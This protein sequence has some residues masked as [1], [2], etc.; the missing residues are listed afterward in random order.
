MAS[1]P[2]DPVDT[3]AP[4]PKNRPRARK[5]TKIRTGAGTA[6]GGSVKTRG[7]HFIGRDF[8][9][10]VTNEVRQGENLDE[11]RSVIAHYL[12]ALSS[13][14]TGLKLGEID[15][16]AQETTREPLQLA[17]VYVPLDTHLQIPH[18]ASLSQW[19]ARSQRGTRGEL[20]TQRETRPV[21]ALE[22]LARHREL[23]V[24]GKPGS[25]K[26]TFGASVLLALAQSWQGHHDELAKLGASW[27]HGAL[28]PIRIILRRFAE[29]LPPGDQPARA[30]DLWDFIRRDLEAGGYGLSADTM[31]Y[32]RRIARN[33]GAL[34]LLDG[35][36]ECGGNDTRR[37]VLAAVEEIKVSA[38]QK[39]RFLLTARPYAW[40]GGPAPVQGVYALADLNDER[41][42][43][44]IQGWYGARC[45]EMAPAG[46]SRAQ[47]RRSA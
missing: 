34:L 10:I 14:L 3:D 32:V 46:G 5:V 19:L 22:A 44:F 11:A 18:D 38:G 33:H 20:E 40:P 43:Q 37:R 24:L 31:E 25:G 2:T 26:S 47:A 41:V 1:K 39:C 30:G 36:D 21:S 7:G 16:A 4:E 8:V 12:A 45:A 6:I 23:T 9:Q 13:D 28:L 42:E 17:D 27:T 15:V 35:L 29:Q